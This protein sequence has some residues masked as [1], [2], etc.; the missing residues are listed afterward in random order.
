MLALSVD[1]NEQKYKNFLRRI[2]VSFLTARDPNAD[3]SA[4][5]GT[6]QYPETYIIKDGRVIRKFAESED[7]TSDDIVRLMKTLVG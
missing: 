2:P 3:V 5:Y 1:T 4:K 7:W 6:F